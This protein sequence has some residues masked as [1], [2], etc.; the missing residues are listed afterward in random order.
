MIIVDTNVISEPLRSEPD[1]AV[2]AWLDE[3]ALETLYLT[4]ITIAELRFGVA[5][6]PAGKR[7]RRLADRIERHVFAHFTGRILSFD[8]AATIPYARL[9][10]EAR[11]KGSAIGD[12]DAL[13]AAIALTRDFAVATRDTAP[14][15]SAG[16]E[17][18]NPFRQ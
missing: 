1:Q 17:V 12:L 13:I 7:S 10:S 18:I 5:A 8:E 11:R 9:R 14:F 3:Q 16:L 15:E 2:V 4:T 6:L